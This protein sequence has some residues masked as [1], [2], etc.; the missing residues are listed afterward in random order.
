M[1]AVDVEGAPSRPNAN[2][3][4]N[5]SKLQLGELYNRDKLNR[6]LEN[7]RQLM[8]ENGYYKAQSHRGEHF[9]RRQTSRSTFS[10]TSIPDRRRM[11]AK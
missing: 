2:Q 5:A 9:E 1:G 3:I 11:S 4:V 6:A 8:Q 10:F 7:I